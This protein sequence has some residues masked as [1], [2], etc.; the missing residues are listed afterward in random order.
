MS[1]YAAPSFWETALDFVFQD[2]D[3]SPVDGSTVTRFSVGPDAEYEVA[4]TKL[5]QRQELSETQASDDANHGDGPV[6]YHWSVY[7]DPITANPSDD[8]SG[9]KLHLGQFHQRDALGKSDAPALMFNLSDNG[10]LVAQFEGAVGKR[11]HVLV[12]GGADG[13]AAKGHWIDIV[14]G[15]DWKLS[16]GWTEFHIRQQGEL[17]YHLAA[18]DTGP[19]TSTGEVYFKYGV[20]RSFLERDS[21]L[22]DSVSSAQFSEVTRAATMEQILFDQPAAP[23]E[24]I[25]GLFLSPIDDARTEADTLFVDHFDLG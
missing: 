22:A 16:G 13:Q 10:D 23:A 24:E 4:G 6:W 5:S 15:A 1:D 7:I 17:D 9:A 19:N 12:S 8:D 21:L 11:A 20:Y 2:A 14:I 18:F 25:S 3:G